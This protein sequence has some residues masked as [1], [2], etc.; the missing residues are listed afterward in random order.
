MA[1]KGKGKSSNRGSQGR[2]RPATAPRPVAAPGRRLPWYHTNAGRLALGLGIAVAVGLIWWVISSNQASNDR[3]EARQET[4][5]DYTGQ[6]RT[7]TQTIT[8]SATEMSAVAPEP[9]DAAIEGLKDSATAWSKT[10]TDAQATLIETFPPSASLGRV[11]QLFGQALQLYDSAAQTY[12]LVPDADGDLRVQLL[13]RAA[14]QRDQASALWTQA[15]TFV[16]A[17]RASAE[18]DPSSLTAPGAG[19]EQPTSLPTDLPTEIPSPLPSAVESE[20]GG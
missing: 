10:F 6:I 2:R 8:Q 5:N 4:L 11:N 16:D 18:M 13:A 3:L 14:A 12:R 17:Q 15:V 7:L 19:T 1:L 9:D 20:G